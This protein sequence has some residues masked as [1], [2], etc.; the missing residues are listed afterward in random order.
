M[1]MIDIRILV[2]VG[3]IAAIS[4][5]ASLEPRESCPAGTQEL[6]DCP[7]LGAI[8]DPGIN[9]LYKNRTWLPPDEL[10]IDPVELGKQAEIPVQHA[11]AKFLG[12]KSEDAL[13]SL[14]AKIWLIE[15][16]GH[17][18]D[19]TYYIF[20]RDLI[21]EAM[22]GALC[23]AVKRGVD[24]RFM[25]D[26]LGSLDADHSA[27]KAMEQCAAEAGFMRNADGVL[28]TKKARI[29]VVVFNAISKVFINANRRS[30]DKLLIVDGSFPD[31]AIAM[32]GGR[33]ISLSYYGINADGS[34]NPDTYM[35]AEI[36]VRAGKSS[37]LDEYTVGQVSEIYYTLLFLFENNKRLLAVSSAS[38]QRIYASDR[39]IAQEKL[40]ELKAIPVVKKHMEAMPAFLAEGWHD[41]RVLLAHELGNLTD[42]N[43]V[44]DAIGNME[45]NP[46]SITHLL[47]SIADK[48]FKRARIVS[49]YLF[50]THYFDE[51]DNE[52]H[53]GAA[54]AHKWLEDN[55][56]S[57]FE[58]ITN[59]VLTSDNFPAQAII[60]M[61]MAPRLLLTEEM[62][63]A[64]LAKREESELNPELV[65]SEAWRKLINHPRLMIYE[66]GRLDDRQL[67]GDV[68]YGKLHAKYIIIDDGGFV[69]T[70]NFDYRS[71]LLNN[72]MGF[73][74]D[75]AGLARQL[76]ADFELL[77]SR[78]YRWGSP[79]WLQMRREVFEIGGMKGRTAEGQRGIYK[80]L[81][82]TG[83]DRQF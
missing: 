3:L 1:G 37:G 52:I 42:K 62:Q 80:T 32:T 20:K 2:A 5:C 72:E 67:G 35:D 61:D 71:R 9:E 69:G 14:V 51:D 77:K 64:W 25:V 44:T 16:A 40:A 31:R 79:E 39:R 47:A 11:R 19:A 70:T 10:K 55:P 65:E 49:P 46:N 81:K 57:T 4:G 26:S 8:D 74:F 75:S 60:D 29:Q 78:S 24:V 34:P 27:L 33:N 76:D 50:A 48:D 59:S 36:L 23:N 41:S 54:A 43:V 38:A 21:G 56:D 58:I 22:L 83:L 18:I 13:N 68:D 12:A 53:D 66:T 28:T 30:H 73:F 17:T 7:P 15:N 63:I 45:R 6:R 82:A